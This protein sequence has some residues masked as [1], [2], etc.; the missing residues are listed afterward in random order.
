MVHHHQTTENT[1]PDCPRC[2]EEMAQYWADVE[3]AKLR[4]AAE[5]V[6]SSLYGS[7]SALMRRL[8]QDHGIRV[9]FEEAQALLGRL[10]AAGVVGPL[11]T[12][13]Y[14]HPVL[15][16]RETALTTMGLAMV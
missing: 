12:R 8:G 5:M 9:S 2:Q 6:T 7:P 13:T 10:E 15:M 3:T 4:T 14:T 11:D 16:D 1:D